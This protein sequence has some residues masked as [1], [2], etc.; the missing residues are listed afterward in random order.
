MSDKRTPFGLLSGICGV[1]AVYL[2]AAVA[3]AHLIM[4]RIDAETQSE[5]NLFGT[6]W[7]ILLFILAAFFAVC[8]VV[9]FVLR[10]IQGSSG[11]GSPIKNIFLNKT[12]WAMV[13]LFFVIGSIG[14]TVGEVF[15]R[16]NEANINYALNINTWEQI[17]S[18]TSGDSIYFK[19]PYLKADGS[20]DD[21]AMRQG[22]MDI[23]R[24]AAAEG[25]VLLW[26]NNNALPLQENEKISFFGVSS[27]AKN[28]HYTGHGSGRVSVTTTDFPD[29]KATF[30]S[31]GKFSVNPTLWNS[32]ANKQVYQL[33]SDPFENDKHYREFKV[34]EKAWA[35]VEAAAGS[36]F[37]Q[38]GDAAIYF[39]G[40]T[41]AED[42]DTWYDTSLA[43]NSSKGWKDEGHTD[44]NYLDLNKNE[45]DTLAA[46]SALKGTTFKKLILVLNTGAAMQ[47]QTIDDYDIDACIWAGMGGNASFGALY[48]VISGKVNPSG[49]LID[50]YVYQNDSAPSVV[51]TGAYTF[52]RSGSLPADNFNA[53]SYN[54][55]YIV[56]QEGIYVGYRYYETRYEDSVLG[57]GNASSAAGAVNSAS[58]WSYQEEVKFPFG[59]G[60]SYTTF[61]FSDMT[62]VEKGGDYHVTV[63]VTNTGLV[64]GKTPVQIYLQKPYTDYDKQYNIEKASVELVGYT[65]TDV[66]Q[67]GESKD[68]T[69]VVDDYEFKTYDAY[70]M[71]T[72]ILEAGDYYLAAGENAHDAL[73]NIIEAKSSVGS[74]SVN[75]DKMVDEDGNKA[76]G[77]N[78]L[79]YKKTVDKNDYKKY[80]TSPT[81]YP[82]TNQFDDADLNLYEGTADQKITYLSRSNWETTYPTSHVLL[83]A[84][85]TI[86]VNDMQLYTSIEED[87]NATMPLYETVTYEGGALSL[88]MLMDVD[89]DNELWDHLLNQLSWTETINLCGIGNHIISAV[90]SVGSPAVV[91]QDGPAGVKVSLPEGL[92]SFMAFPAGVV[93]ASTF[94]DELVEKTMEAFALEMLHSGCG[95]IYGT[96][97]GIHRSAYGGRNWEY[98]SEDGFLSG[99]ILAAEVKGLQKYGAIVNIKHFVLNDQEIYRCGAA[100]FANE[101]SIREIYLK[102][103][104]AGITEGKANGLMSSLNRIG[105]TWA[106]RHKG[107]LTEVLRNEWGFIG[108]V[109]TDAATGN[110][111]SSGGARAQAII[112]GNDLWLRGSSNETELWGDYKDN[113][114][115]CQ[116]L[117]ESA[118]RILYTVLHSFSMNGINSSTK[119]VYVEPFYFGLLESAQNIA[120]V[121]TAFAGVM[122]LLS[123]ILNGE[124]LGDT[125]WISGILILII[126]LGIAAGVTAV[127]LTQ[128]LETEQPDN[129]PSTIVPDNPPVDDGH[130]CTSICPTCGFCT[131]LYC[132]SAACATKCGDSEMYDASINAIKVNVAKDGVTLVTKEGYLADF[133][134]KNNSSVVFAFRASKADTM[135]LT[136]A[137]SRGASEM[138]FTDTVD[139][140]VNGE[141]IERA[142]VVPSTTSTVGVSIVEL[143][144]GCIN[145]LEGENV[146]TLL[147]KQDG[148]SYA[149]SELKLIG[150][151]QITFTQ[152]QAPEHACTSVCST[153][154]GCKDFSCLNAGCQSK[155]TCQ[156]GAPATIFSVLDY[157]VDSNKDINAEYDGI[158][159]TWN[160]ETLIT[161]KIIASEAG[162]VK[163]GAVTSIDTVK[164]NLFTTQVITKVN[165]TRITGTG[166]MPTGGTRVWNTYVMLVVGEIQLKEGENIITLSHT[167]K[168]SADGGTNGAYNIQ[169]IIIFGEGTYVWAE[170]SVADPHQL[171]HVASKPASCTEDGNLEHYYC[172]ECQKYYKDKNGYVALDSIVISAKG[173]SYSSELEVLGATT[174]YD[175]GESFKTDGLSVAVACK[176]CDHKIPVTDYTISKTG[177]LESTDTAIAI[178]YKLDD[179]T[180]VVIIPITVAHQHSFTY[181]AANAATCTDDGNVEYYHCTV[182]LK[183]YADEGGTTEI[184]DVVIKANG[185]SMTKTA[186]KAATCIAEGNVEYYHCSVCDKNFSDADGS[187]AITST[188][189]PVDTVGGHKEVTS[190]TEVSCTLCNKVVR[191]DFT[192]FDEHL[193][194]SKLPVAGE[195][196]GSQWNNEVHFTYT[197]NAE[198]AGKV[199]LMAKISQY[200]TKKENLFTDVYKIYLN[201]S[202]TPL[203]GTG[204]I[205]KHTATAW[206]TFDTV[207]IGEF[208][209]VEGKNT[210]TFSYT[211]V[212]EANGGLGVAHNFIM[213]SIMGEGS[214]DWFAHVCT[215]KCQYCGKCTTDC[216]DPICQDKCGCKA[217]V[218]NAMD[219]EIAVKG[220]SKNQTELCIGGKN[221]VVITISFTVN[222]SKAGKY[223]I[224][225]NNSAS[226][227]VV[228]L[229]KTFTSTI[230]GQSFVSSN[231]G[232]AYDSGRGASAKYFDYLF[233]Y[234]GEVELNEGNNE[235]VFVLT[236]VS[237]V[238]VKDFAFVST[239]PEAILTYGK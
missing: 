197:I 109:E 5:A 117:R 142:T 145:V 149:I 201:G 217:Y 156:S 123:L 174:S 180:Y 30:E 3:I 159:S 35:D 160:Q 206:T 187:K 231:N 10:L 14:L 226:S 130:K 91:A 54:H 144:L 199:T 184:A 175:P 214:Y 99:K 178:S 17:T 150:D 27:M 185:H 81:G 162:T 16:E 48:D 137:V 210:I 12:G 173:H 165:G 138:V 7:Q 69:V 151:P 51:N 127:F 24:E 28:W 153:C 200:N 223:K 110:Y 209:L 129:P 136:V 225:L 101:Q 11:S 189:L 131:D 82:V 208:E 104:E 36:S 49:R 1:F 70:N 98:F 76:S 67:P 100:T 203:V 75:R 227:G 125:N 196:I 2:S 166:T 116:A 80:S 32:Y 74:I 194:T 23:S 216:A 65:K 33:L 64:A 8:T 179:V 224:Y 132:T 213:L 237:P 60:L 105:A 176:N 218:F 191:Y 204:Y 20:F 235:I 37:V 164:N 45:R 29:L 42:G 148:I 188:T 78:S 154:G 26:N 183:N 119:F 167:P 139:V 193:E 186:A 102:G 111:M 182:C 86:F 89:Y 103:F 71:G 53:N 234:Y 221:N 239:D 25:M 38:Y 39:I 68:Y 128:N 140:L 87:V 92:N 4:G 118:H 108:L 120:Y 31:E 171:T 126:I 72:Y 135:T 90:P 147:P 44:N 85:N 106:G 215:D 124:G 152:A 57:L 47:M 21:A 50:T 96:G 9:L 61:D 46:L 56:Y 238:N 195:G 220:V 77:D 107:L 122:L 158:G 161:F 211:P 146:I 88:I 66:L 115:V 40:R 19:S 198:K 155:C 73:N 113:P 121:L 229:S 134:L 163:L 79:V 219:D 41:G 62:V 97:A 222:A 63:T 172:A 114:T 43:V 93:L 205:P 228:A 34:N 15:V 190:G 170:D 177:A 83:Q 169:S 232:H 181:T 157:R 233:D 58:G 13:T 112:A 52:T 55:Q 192:V 84:R 168:K 236:G 22:S 18:D 6:W 143:N 94:N 207:V 59:Y 212:K 230:N 202:T 95:E 141:R 133:S